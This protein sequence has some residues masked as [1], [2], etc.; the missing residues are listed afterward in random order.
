M[1]MEKSSRKELLKIVG[2][3]KEKIKNYEIRLGDLVRAYKSL[4]KEKEALESTVKALNVVKQ[5]NQ[6]EAFVE[7]AQI[8]KSR[9]SSEFSDP[10]NAMKSKENETD[11]QD[12]VTTLLTSLVVLTEEKSRLEA[13]LL[14]DKK[15]LILE[16]EE[17]EKQLEE[18]KLCHQKEIQSRD[19]EVQDLK[20]KIR[21]QQRE[22][23][24]EQEN[25]ALMLRELQ[26]LVAD[27]RALKESF[28]RKCEEIEE[29]RKETKNVNNVETYKKKLKELKSD[30]TKVKKELDVSKE[31]AS[32]TPPMLLE[33]K[34]QM[35]EMKISHQQAVE[36]EKHRVSEAEEKLKALS[37]V[38]EARI[39]SLE[40]RVSELSE[41]V[42][43]YDR[44]KQKDQVAIQ[45]LKDRVAQLD[46]ENTTLA[47]AVAE[48][49]KKVGKDEDSN[50]DVQTLMDKIC[51]YK[52]ILKTANDRSENP[53]DLNASACLDYLIEFYQHQLAAEMDLHARCQEDLQQLKE[54]FEQYKIRVQSV[55]KNRNKNLE[56]LDN[57]K[58]MESLKMQLAKMRERLQ[59]SETKL[60]VMKDSY[61]KTISELETSIQKIKDKHK[62]DLANQEAENKISLVELEQQMVRQRE[63]TATLLEEK[64]REL[65][66]LKFSL[67]FSTFMEKRYDTVELAP[68]QY[69]KKHVSSQEINN[70]NDFTELLAHS[71][72]P[73]SRDNQILYYV[74]ELSRKDVELSGLRQSRHQAE[75]AL[76][77]LQHS[78]LEKE[79]KYV[80][81]IESLKA[82]IHRLESSQLQSGTSM[83][84]LKNV[85]LQYMLCKD[86]CDRYHML[87]AIAKL[88]QYTKREIEQVR[89]F[90]KSW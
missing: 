75:T 39:A 48:D 23:E 82:R 14:S 80:E 13:N 33:L 6:T 79:E 15:K 59:A 74:Q 60:E 27:E 3:Q 54:E 77:E 83:E 71:F 40:S 88:L 72:R 8:E 2:D 34:Q 68:H 55:V 1:L 22:R 16:K 66:Q 37:A 67:G 86:P 17:L 21:I 84:Y 20:Q 56:E 52:N 10:L 87:N 41:V 32:E 61:Q 26:H 18:M 76:R 70:E 5:P 31:K 49:D 28:E 81:E 44:L 25:H 7:D 4:T 11:E 65:E 51:K 63:R 89:Q 57:Q 50:L 42:G 64:N 43:S 85:V 58:D 19:Q 24:Q 69:N 35:T 45:R 73:S 36:Q 30:L 90:N 53:V 47:K 29:K 78:A 62:D 12:Q 46:L 9:H 38:S